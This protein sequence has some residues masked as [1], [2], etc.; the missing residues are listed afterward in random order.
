[1]IHSHWIH[2]LLFTRDMNWFD[3][4]M[5]VGA[6]CCHGTLQLA[7]YAMHLGMGC[8]IICHQVK[9]CMIKKYVLNVS[10]F[11]QLFDAHS[12]DFCYDNSG[13]S[14]FSPVLQKVYNELEHW[15]NV[16]NHWEPF[17]LEMLEDYCAEV[18]HKKYH[19]DSLHAAMLDWFKIGL[20]A[21]L[22]KSEFAQDAGCYNTDYPKMNFHHETQAFCLRDVYFQSSM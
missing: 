3:N 14:K 13:E 16:P 18:I 5:L 4:I 15:E 11:L 7:I 8:T 17:T 9:V 20:F 19:E 1:M 22:H 6:L 10:H 2:Y 12:F 21:G